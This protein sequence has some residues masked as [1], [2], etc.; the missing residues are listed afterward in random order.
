MYYERKMRRV[1]ETIVAVETQLSITYSKRVSAALT[2]QQ[3]E[4]MRRIISSS[5]TCLVLPHFS[6]NFIINGTIF[7]GWGRG[8]NLF[9]RK[10][11]VLIFSTP[12][13]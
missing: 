7:R 3:T 11:C 10:M 9:E 2:I 1:R 4:R 5:V 6:P 8:A 12:F 13:T